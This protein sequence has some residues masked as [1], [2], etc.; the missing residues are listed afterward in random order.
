MANWIKVDVNTPYKDGILAIMEDCRCDRATAFFAWFTLYVWF[1]AQTASGTLNL[2]PAEVDTHAG[3]PGT[4]AALQRAGWLTFRGRKC[5]IANWQEHNS[6]SA[7]ARSERMSN[8]A[9]RRWN[10]PPPMRHA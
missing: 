1:D 7:R 4:A 5:I 6:A 3:L 10:P 9:K 2:S 8:L